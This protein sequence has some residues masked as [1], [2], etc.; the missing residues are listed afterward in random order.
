MEI[1]EKGARHH[2]LVINKIDTEIIQRCWNKAYEKH[3]PVK[4][5]NLDKS[6]NYGKLANY[7]LKYTSKHRKKEEGAL[8]Q[9]RWSA[10]KNLSRPE[11]KVTIISDRD[12]FRTE[13]K[14]IKGYYVDKESVNIGAHS[15]E[16]YGYGY[17]RYTLV[18]L[19]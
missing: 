2:H 11:P 16:Y 18:Q 3:N 6:G 14:A 1:G 10:S 12:Y 7:L 15:A 8:Q 13:V 19:E 5:F 17:I 4:V 9:K